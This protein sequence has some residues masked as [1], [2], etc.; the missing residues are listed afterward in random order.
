MDNISV[1]S[2]LKD[3]LSVQVFRVEPTSLSFQDESWCMGKG[4]VP[5]GGWRRVL[6]LQTSVVLSMK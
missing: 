4:L 3:F 2:F 5:S 6:L 1:S